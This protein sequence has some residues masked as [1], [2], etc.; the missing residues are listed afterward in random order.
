[1]SLTEDLYKELILEHAQNPS[2]SGRLV[3]PTV[4]EEG[5]NRSCGDELELELK[6]ADGV[7]QGIC[8]NG[9]GCSISIASASMMADAVDGMTTEQAE[10]L[11][12]NFKSMILEEKPVNLPE[13][14]EEL[15]SLQGVKKYPIRVKCATLPWNTLEQALE[16]AVSLQK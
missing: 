6:V 10:A 5:V 1:M 4:R 15:E 2:H 13:E 7:I 14:F 12:D 16:R 9:R 11:I 8:I 3:N